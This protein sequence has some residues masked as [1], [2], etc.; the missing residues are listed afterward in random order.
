MK[1]SFTLL[2]VCLLSFFGLLQE[3][4]G[5][6]MPALDIHCQSAA[7][8]YTLPNQLVGIVGPNDVMDTTFGNPCPDWFPWMYEPSYGSFS[9]LALGIGTYQ[10]SLMSL[11]TS[12]PV[13]FLDTCTTTVTVLEDPNCIPGTPLQCK[14]LVEVQLNTNGTASRHWSTLVEGT[15]CLNGWSYQ[16]DLEPFGGNLETTVSLDI[17]HAGDT[18]DF[19][20][21]SFE[22]S[23]QNATSSCSG[24]IVVTSPPCNIICNDFLQVVLDLCNV[25]TPDHEAYLEGPACIGNYFY[26]FDLAPLDGIYTPPVTFN[27][28]HVG[29]TL[30]LVVA[31]FEGNNSTPASTCTTHVAIYD[32]FPGENHVVQGSVFHDQNE[33]CAFDSGE[34]LFENWTVMVTGQPSGEVYSTTTDAQGNYSI[35][36]CPDETTAQIFLDLPYNYGGT[37]CPTT[38]ELSF[39]PG[40]ADTLTQDIGA[41]L[42]DE[43]P[44]MVVDMASP[45]IRPCFDGYY[46]VSFANVST[47][48]IEDTYIDVHLDDAL[49]FTSSPQP[50]TDLGN[51]LF[52]FDVGDLQPGEAGQFPIYFFTDCNATP[53]ATHCSEVHIYPDT[54]CPDSPLWFGA[55]IEVEGFCENDTVFFTIKNTGTGPSQTLDFVVVEDFIMYMKGTFSLP[56]NTTFPL[57]PIPANGSTYRLEAD[58]EPGHPYGG[59]PAI[60]VEGCAG[61]TQG[62]VLQ[63]PIGNASP[64]IERVC[65]ENVSSFDPNEKEASPRGYGNDHLI[66]PSTRL[67]YTIHFQNTGTDTAYQVVVMDTLSQFLDASALQVL[68]G[69][70]PYRFERLNGNVLRFTFEGINLPDSTTNYLGSQGFVKFQIPQMPNNPIGMVIEN[71]AAIYFDYNDPIFTNT[72]FHTVDTNFVET[73]VI[74]DV[75]NLTSSFGELLVYPNPSAGDVTFE[76]PTEMDVKAT[77]HLFDTMGRQEVLGIFTE[78]KCHFQRNGLPSGLYFYKVE[79]DGF[80]IYSGKVILK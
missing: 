65:Q 28:S 50:N 59:M 71:R 63:F 56:S 19:E 60:A 31:A 42:D 35:S 54:L 78:N 80:R 40:M 2:L 72:T 68:S 49:S 39:T 24:Q 38:Y 11:V 15:Y 51:G 6:C 74:N 66:E 16:M 29:D 7:T 30:T 57:D 61:F 47:E 55:N 70:H 34:M 52:R 75:N 14:D 20:V 25:A 4:T 48:L 8:V 21:F 36:L 26:L 64:F 27:S 22:G 12:N 76:I 43:C 33:N 41:Q 17:S 3:L 5:Q 46:S 23:N 58:Q 13:T 45:R 10:V 32:F 53:G 73:I 77:F 37:S 79:T 62:M 44:H 18:L 1:S 9:E 67:D 69:S